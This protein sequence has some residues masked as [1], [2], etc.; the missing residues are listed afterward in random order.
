MHAQAALPP[1]NPL[2]CSIGYCPVEIP[3]MYKTTTTPKGAYAGEKC[4][5]S[6]EDFVKDPLINHYWTLDE[7]TTTQGKAN[8]RARQFLYWV[9]TKS[10]IDQHPVIRQI[11]TVTQNI[12]LFMFLL[13]AALFGLGYIVG[14]RSDFQLKMQIWPIIYKIGAGLLYIVFS[15]AI[16]MTFVQLSEVIM[17]FFIESLGGDRLFNIYFAG[18]ESKEISYATFV[19]CRD[20]N[21]KVQEAIKAEM[22]LMKVTNITYYAMGIMMLLRKILLWFLLFA[23]P[24]LALLMPF[25]F[26]RNVGW[27]W[28][29]TFAQWIFYGPLFALFLGALTKIW[30]SGIPF[31]FDF[32]RTSSVAGYIYPTGINIVYGGPA[33]VGSQ[34][35][36]TLNNGNYIDTFAEYVISL[37][38]LW[39][40]IIFPWFLLRIFRDYCCDG[41]MAMKN[42]LMSMYDRLAPPPKTPPPAPSASHSF[43]NTSMKI[44]REVEVP[45][46]VKLE[47]LQEI[48]QTKT[49]DITKSLNLSMNKI[50]D[51]AKF[52]TNKQT[53]ETVRKNIDMLSQ[54]TKA[55]T[56][57]ERQKFMNIRTELFNRTI[58]DDKVAR[59]ILSS[60]SSSRTES[61]TRKE[62]I[63]R[64]VPRNAPPVAYKV[65]ISNDKVTSMNT[66]LVN[67]VTSNT[68]VLAQIAQT[69]QAP[70]QQ[71]QTVLSSYKT[72][73][74][75]AP[76]EILTNITKETGI[77]SETVKS[78]IKAIASSIK[79]NKEV[80][81]KVAEKEQM[82]EE[83][84]ERVIETQTPLVSEPEKTIEQLVS[85][86]PSVSIEDYEEVKKMWTQQYEKGEVPSS[87]NITSREQWVD[88]DVVF[89]T[90]TL[91]KLLSADDKLRQEGIDDLAYI[92]PIFLINSLKGEEL[93]V[94]LKAKI[95]AAKAVKHDMDK[96]REITEQ[97]PN[98][99][100][101][102]ANIDQL[103]DLVT[104]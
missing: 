1:A 96:E 54:P 41:I 72:N 103:G 37:I 99:Q 6:Y 23:A 100:Y 63:L 80:V 48:K 104:E 84:V 18:K 77:A 3:P 17:K 81:K 67:T 12:T 89:I 57:A 35:I 101:Q 79:K 46:K 47:T 8:E 56:P 7:P 2:P 71:I 4:V 11:W 68:S 38:M 14:Q 73:I 78:I 52:E 74:A 50:T 86:P 43:N 60:I 26:I 91:N 61:S 88:Q 83:D 24:F 20:L 5:T 70:A 40:V 75:H 31:P 16:I 36:G 64:T 44:N 9:L 82:K 13:V 58:K 66:T 15:Y 49:E 87:E 45:I 27:I 21:Y 39:A 33:Q 59:Q 95:E 22:Y 19:G 29:G 34:L 102:L 94:Y 42:V 30:Q 55:G 69:T 93:I 97:I 28:I 25:V 92:L 76:G 98:R 51:I 10:A 53:N 32:S 62:E 90:N 85:I 65:N